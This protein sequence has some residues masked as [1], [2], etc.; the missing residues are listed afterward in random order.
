MRNKATIPGG[1]S[2]EDR[3]TSI[4]RGRGDS[5]AIVQEC[6]R[7]GH[8]AITVGGGTL[9]IRSHRLGPY[10]IFHPS[11]SKLHSTLSMSLAEINELCGR[12]SLS[13]GCSRDSAMVGHKRDRLDQDSTLQHSSI[14]VYQHSYMYRHLRS[15][16][17]NCVDVSF[18]NMLARNHVV[19]LRNLKAKTFKLVIG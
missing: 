7:P 15:T 9:A 5:D 19:M 6:R 10:F 18:E 11:S 12:L 4:P 13:S 2:I 8:R 16:P 14:C 17:C 3:G 1:D